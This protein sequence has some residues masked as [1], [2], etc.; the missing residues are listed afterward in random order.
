ML[1][2]KVLLQAPAAVRRR[3][4][5]HWLGEA[6]GHLLR[7]EMSHLLSV[8]KLLTGRGGSLAEL[9]GGFRV[10]RNGRFLKVFSSKDGANKRQS[11]KNPVG[12]GKRALKKRAAPSKLSRR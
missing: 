12:H 7:L 6:R 11:T 1:S 9:P 3:A 5:R 8:E 10:V 4:L 2:V